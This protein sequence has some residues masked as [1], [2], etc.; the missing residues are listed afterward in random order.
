[1]GKARRFAGQDPIYLP[2]PAAVTAVGR[3][4][5]VSADSLCLA[6]QARYNFIPQ[7][8]LGQARLL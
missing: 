7:R 8:L 5:C 1:M 6:H 3:F 4:H 2:V